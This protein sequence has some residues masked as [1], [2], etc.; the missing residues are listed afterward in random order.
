MDKKLKIAVLGATGKVGSHF[1]KQ[2][3]DKG[4]AL[5]VL[6]RSESKF[7]YNKNNNISVVVGNST[8]LKDVEKVMTGVDYVVSCLGNV[9]INKKYIHIMK[10]SHTNILD[11][12]AKQNK[13][14]RCIF[15]SSIGCGGS[16]WLIKAMLIMIGGKDG[17]ND[18][19]AADKQIREQSIVPSILVR[20]YAL[21]DN[22]ATGLYKIIKKQTTH[23][24]KPISRTDLASCLVDIIK[25][26]FSNDKT[27]IH[28]GGV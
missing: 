24:A 10:D 3:L 27:V 14:P 15:I 28:V 7:K 22:P 8:N 4:Y 16:S 18:Y 19:E 21:N 11:I 17:F 6:V 20:P 23:F 26:N 1:V 13:I 12:A 2:A 5:Q 25:N 9:K